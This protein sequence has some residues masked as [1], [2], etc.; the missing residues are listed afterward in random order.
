[1]AERWAVPR[2]WGH[3][4]IR[5]QSIRAQSIGG[6][7]IAGIVCRAVWYRRVPPA[8]VGFDAGRDLRR[9]WPE[10]VTSSTKRLVALER[11]VAV[12]AIVTVDWPEIIT[13]AWQK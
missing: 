3:R 4:G 11:L 5:A 2:L 7:S 12:V 9:Y 1:M 10:I 13:S 8:S 6:Q